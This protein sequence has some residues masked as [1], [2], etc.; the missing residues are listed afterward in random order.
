M[1]TLSLVIA[2][3]L[4]ST[5]LFADADLSLSPFNT[6]PVIFQAGARRAVTFN[7]RNAGPDAARDVVVT[8]TATRGVSMGACETG[9][10]L[11]PS[12]QVIATDP[13]TFDF[14]LPD[15]PGDMV[16]TATVSS[17]TPDPNPGNNRAT[18]TVIA[19]PDPDVAISLGVT[20]RTDLGQP[21]PVSV[22]LSNSSAIVAHDVN[23]TIDFRPDAAVKSLPAGCTTPAAGRVVCHADA[24]QGTPLPAT[25]VITLVAPATFG[26][27]TL[28]L[29][30]TV[31][32]REHDFDPTSNV[33]TI[34]APLYNTR[35]VTTTADSGAS[36]LRQAILDANASSDDAPSIGFRI[37]VPSATAWKTIHLLSP[38]P[39]ITEYGIHIDGATQTGFFG[40]TNPDGPEIEISGG[41]NVDGDGVVV[42]TCFAEVANL[43]IGGFRGNG[44]SVAETT[45][46]GC[47]SFYTTELHHLDVGTDPAGSAAQPNGRGIGIST[48]GSVDFYSS[49]F[50]GSTNIHD[51]IISGN[52]H[53]GIFGL[54]GRLNISNNRIGVKAHADEPLPNGASGVFIGPGC[55]GSDVGPD[56]F[57]ALNTPTIGGNVIAFN[58]ETGVAIASGLR[59]VAVRNNRIWGNKLLGIDI[60]LDGPTISSQSDYGD[61]IATPTLTL[62]H[63]DPVSKKTIIEGDIP[64]VVNGGV[65]NFTINFF[66]NDAGDPSGYGEGQRSLGTARV[67]LPSAHFHFEANGDLTGQFITATNTRSNY[68]G[69]AKPQPDGIDQGFL[70]Q[71]SEFSRWLEVR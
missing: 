53:S 30:A 5:A 23:A 21:L 6:S 48:P 36:S 45:T 19:S 61:P 38:L 17:S 18:A 16:I 62:A 67:D 26:A 63:Y 34:A 12:L 27:G 70:T 37:D 32:E 66:A 35:Y 58:G 29:S 56:V 50:R 13:L 64:Q 2:L 25:F 47:P 55:Y 15:T 28:P 39:A 24:V 40:D 3:T 33:W 44:L 52:T 10:P 20:K 4:S 43:A 59:D 11:T 22:Y 31:T 68:V 7:L 14:Q 54:S 60:G 42:A 1:K 46:P 51:C 71:T 8:V 65:F 41:G 57:H 9:C 69:F 49:P